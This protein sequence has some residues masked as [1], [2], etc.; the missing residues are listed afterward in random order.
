[1]RRDDRLS[2]SRR[3][4]FAQAGGGLIGVSATVVATSLSGLPYAQAQEHDRPLPYVDALQPPLDLALSRGHPLLVMVSL[5]GCPFCKVARMNYL[6]PIMGKDGLVIVQVDMRSQ[7]LIANFQGQTQSQDALV[8][9]WKIRIA[10]TVLFFGKGGAE[11]VER[12]E[13][14]YIPDFYGAYLDERLSLAR[15]TIRESRS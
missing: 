4:W 15:K 8:R 10:P 1:M 13:G 9:H 3:V 12:L 14:A 2:I 7:R 5:D 6:R 11:V